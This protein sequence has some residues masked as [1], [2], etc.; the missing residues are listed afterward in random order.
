MRHWL[1]AIATIYFFTSVVTINA[2][3][4][5]F[6]AIVPHQP[7]LLILK[8]RNLRTISFRRQQI[9]F[10]ILIVIISSMK[11]DTIGYYLCKS[12]PCRCNYR[13]AFTQQYHVDHATVPTLVT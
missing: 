11:N 1:A 9:H 7:G 2:K 12:T 3:S 13:I 8:A 6:A 10:T 5:P 4:I